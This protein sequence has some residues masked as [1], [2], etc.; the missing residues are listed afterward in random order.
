MQQ[1]NLIKVLKYIN[2][3]TDIA[4]SKLFFEYLKDHN[5]YKI[6]PSDYKI[7]EFYKLTKNEKENIITKGQSKQAIKRLNK[8]TNL[9]ENEKTL[10][11][12]IENNFLGPLIMKHD[13]DKI[14][15]K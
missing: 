11:K 9:T 3:K 8:I 5:K 1:E 12:Y 6:S 7:Y 14:I 10:V 13:L 4:I 2:A 15:Y